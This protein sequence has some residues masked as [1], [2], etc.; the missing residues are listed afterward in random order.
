MR[1]LLVR[2]GASH[3]SAAGL[4]ATPRGCTGLTDS[5]FAQVDALARR[6]AA[7]GERHGGQRPRQTTGATGVACASVPSGSARIRRGQPGLAHKGGALG[8]TRTAR[9]G[10]REPGMYLNH[11]HPEIAGITVRVARRGW[12]AIP[13]IRCTYHTAYVLRL[14]GGSGETARLLI[15]TAIEE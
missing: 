2:H 14:P 7:E 15:Y 13:Q 9:L 6:L 1:L 10:R 8:T 12:C 11:I 3:H 4:I 5:D